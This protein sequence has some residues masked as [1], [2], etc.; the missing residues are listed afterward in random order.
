MLRL[1]LPRAAALFR[2]TTKEIVMHTTTRFHRLLYPAVAMLLLVLLNA[3]A[4]TTQSGAVG[5][6]RKQLLL[7]S[8]ESL[9][10]AAAANFASTTQ[11]AQASNA[12][13]QGPEADNLRNIAARLINQVGVFR[14][15]ARRWHWQ[16]ALIN[17]PPINAC[18][19][20]GGNIIF[21]T[22]ILRTLQLNND[23]IAAV[24]GHEIAHALREH[25]RE[26]AT[27]QVGTSLLKSAVNVA[28]SLLGAPS[29]TSTISDTAM[30]YL[31]TLPHS[32]QHES[33]ADRMGLELMARAGY[34]PAAAP[35][36]WRKMRAAGQGGN[37]A[38]MST[39]PSHESRIKDLEA[40]LPT[41]QPLYLAAVGQRDGT[42]R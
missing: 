4:S 21:Y 7:V 26:Q 27:T 38:F 39:H 36:V 31:V 19:M 11:K 28:A 22:G 40:L 14:Q 20:P 41:V 25:A 34:N 1:T 33:E 23:E 9:N 10:Q 32:R 30:T 13:V 37:L 12:L 18:C 3:C 17:S 35:N 15:D 24:M 8:A 42:D 5:A 29:A 2:I 6:N 16:V